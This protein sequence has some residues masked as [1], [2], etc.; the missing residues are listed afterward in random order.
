M[1][2]RQTCIYER[3]NLKTFDQRVFLKLVA[4]QTWRNL[5]MAGQLFWIFESLAYNNVRANFGSHTYTNINISNTY[6]LTQ[7]SNFSTNTWP[8]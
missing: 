2:H 8:T 4:I 6:E 3:E 7:N 1:D 5:E